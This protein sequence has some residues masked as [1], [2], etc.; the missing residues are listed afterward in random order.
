MPP[1]GNRTATRTS[2]A[3]RTAATIA[4][5]MLTTVK[6]S[7]D[8]TR[9]R[10]DESLGPMGRSCES[11]VVS[12]R[13]TTKI[14]TTMAMPIIIAMATT[15]ATRTTTITTTITTKIAI[16]RARE[17]NQRAKTT[18]IITTLLQTTTSTT[19]IILQ[20]MQMQMPTRR[21][22]KRNPDLTIES[23]GNETENSKNRVPSGSKT[24]GGRKIPHCTR[25]NK[26]ENKCTLPIVPF[27]MQPARKPEK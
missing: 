7:G 19:T 2:R 10:E 14:E 11:R 26:I 5:V 20:L 23:A 15:T 16:T 21:N 24:D 13:R 8:P 9:S 6:R 27:T 3:K 4:T 1:F 12:K 17:E 22:P 18:T 25:Y